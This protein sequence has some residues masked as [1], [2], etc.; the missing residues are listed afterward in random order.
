MRDLVK[1]LAFLF[2]LTREMRFSRLTMTTIVV[3]GMISGFAN[4]A[5]LA[6]FNSAFTGKSP[7]LP[8]LIG[9]FAGLC[10]LLP[11]CRLLSQVLLIDLTQRGILELR[12]RLCGRILG[13]PLRQL[14]EIGPHRL[15]AALTS[16]VDLIVDAL[17]LAPLLVMHAA[18]VISCLAYLGWLS[19]SML[20][21]VLGLVVFGVLT[22][23]LPLTL[24]MRRFAAARQWMDGLLKHVRAIA[25][26]TKELKMHELRRQALLADLRTASTA[27]QRETRAGGIVVAAAASWGQALFFVVIGLL[28][29]VL[30]RYHR[31]DSATLLGFTLVLLRL[32]TPLEVLL[33]SA[34]N[35]SRAAA[36]AGA[37]GRL[38]VSLRQTAADA[39][40]AGVAVEPRWQRLEL[41]GVTH[42]YR[43]EERAEGFVLGPID[44]AF[45]PGELVFIAGGNGSGKTT[46]AKL[47]VGLYEP[48]SGEIRFAGRRITAENRHLLSEHFSVVFADFFLFERLLGLDRPVLDDEALRYLR[49][50]R[51]E[52][53]VR[54][55]EGVLS[56]LDLSQGQRKRL[57]LL[58]AYLEDRPLYLFD[59]WAADQDPTFKEIFYLEI[60]PGLKAKAKT[61]FVISHDDRYYQ[62]ADRIIKLEDGKVEFDRPISEYLAL[63][64]ST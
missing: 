3:A 49:E 56:T 10:L 43:R 41:A 4:T 24:A 20:L 2:Q 31:L 5:F 12:L 14:E 16:D 35:L 21:E 9:A 45:E 13:A 54:V 50:L 15:L 38:G 48:E 61:V 37:I 11:G 39:G 32:M 17:A 18:I 26:G 46:L 62:L 55:E 53:K 34:P 40:G 57:A 29:F 59:E 42:E 23:Q 25:E 51:L 63:A 64:A 36:S 22:Y 60:L 19:W 28:L 58:T 8:V 33:G 7:R 52:R 1:L 30:P 27:V 6:L 47:L 44:L